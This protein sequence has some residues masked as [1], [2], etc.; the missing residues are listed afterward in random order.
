MV[1][2]STGS[3]FILLCLCAFFLVRK[4]SRVGTIILLSLVIM[5]SLATADVALTFGMV[6]HDIPGLF[7][8][9]I[10]PD[11]FV[12]HVLLKNPLFVTN[13]RVSTSTFN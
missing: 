6:L 13:K 8:M 4:R 9:K 11:T 1:W 2:T 3:H 10:S 7:K 12:K 5:F